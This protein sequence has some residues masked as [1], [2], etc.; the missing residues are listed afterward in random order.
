MP[1]LELAAYSGY[2]FVAACASLAV[3]LITGALAEPGAC[4]GSQPLF[5]KLFNVL[6]PG[7][8][9]ACLAH[10]CHSH[11]R[12]AGSGAAYH[13]VWAYGSLCCAVFLV[14]PAR[15]HA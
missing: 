6:Q 12:P 10:H 15:M 5:A 8:P 7:R 9:A 11:R 1:I 13:A 2:A 14:R 4:Y 3:Q